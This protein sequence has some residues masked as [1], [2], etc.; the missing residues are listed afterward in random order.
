MWD[1]LNEIDQNYAK[2][3]HPNNYRYVIRALEVKILT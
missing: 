1:K 2:E 3:L